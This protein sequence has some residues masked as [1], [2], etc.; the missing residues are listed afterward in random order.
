MGKLP[1]Y[2]PFS[3]AMLNYQGVQVSFLMDSKDFH[4]SSFDSPLGGRPEDTAQMP[5]S[6]PLKSEEVGLS[7]GVTKERACGGFLKFRYSEQHRYPKVPKPV[8]FSHWYSAILDVGY[9]IFETH[10]YG[11]V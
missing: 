9:H 7:S 10:L 5:D 2:G 4:G 1:R 3:I 8:G 6:Q 11:L